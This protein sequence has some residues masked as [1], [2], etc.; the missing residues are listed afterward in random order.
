MS[1]MKRYEFGVVT[2]EI[3][4]DFARACSIA[5][6]EGMS[7]V[8]LHN[9]WGKPV[10]ELT[11]AE[12]DRALRITAENGL[13]TH[14]VCGMFF[15]PF[16]LA[17]L[18]LD[19]MESHPRFQEHMDRLERFITI[20]HKFKAPNI[21]TFGFTRDV[22]GGN[23]SPRSPDGGGF[24][25]SRRHPRPFGEA[26]TDEETLAKIAKGIRIACRRLQDEGLVL[27]LENARSL[28]AN[29]GGNMR[30]VLDAVQMPNLKIIWDPANAFVAGEDPAVGYQQVKGHI[31]DIHCKDAVVLDESTG[32]TAWAR[33]GAGGTDW[34]AHL[35][36]LQN[37]P[38]DTY[39]VETHW[40]ANGQDKAANTRQTFASLKD[41][42]AALP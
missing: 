15:R 27:A 35:T 38:V 36:L 17:D 19:E 1:A 13:R 32:L 34:H 40:Q 6:E 22:G 20:A 16:S 26:Q 8:E 12:L 24:A 21:R 14:L 9:L 29:T 37:E 7:Y 18:S 25:L 2:D 42:I 10:H 39:T 28:Y 31:V 5:R 23:P 4:Q 30:R 3:D 33:I 41:L 11:D